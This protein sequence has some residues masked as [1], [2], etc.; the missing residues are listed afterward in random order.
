MDYLCGIICA[1][2][3]VPIWLSSCSYTEVDVTP[4]DA[5]ACDPWEDDC[6]EEVDE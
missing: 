2:I 6:E 3:L 4:D 1:A 5:E